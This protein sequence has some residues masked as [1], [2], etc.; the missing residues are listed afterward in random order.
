MWIYSVASDDRYTTPFY[1][2]T[3]QWSDFFGIL[4]YHVD[5]II[6]KKYGR[7]HSMCMFDSRLVPANR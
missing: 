3:A 7:C 5:M 1:E 4:Y 2:S 6:N